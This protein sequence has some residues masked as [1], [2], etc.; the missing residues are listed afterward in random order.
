MTETQMESLKH[1]ASARGYS[2]DR[3]DM[4]CENQLKA[5]A[6]DC[7]IAEC[8]P[9]DDARMTWAVAW[10]VEY[11]NVYNSDPSEDR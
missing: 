11:D 2:G 9:T 7:K 1:E 10:D 6:V 4:T 8:D 3:D 5:F